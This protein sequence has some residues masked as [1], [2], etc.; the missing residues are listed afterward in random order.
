GAEQNSWRL[1]A[2]SRPAAV[3]TSPGHAPLPWPR[4]GGRT[5]SGQVEG[6]GR[7]GGGCA[8]LGRRGGRVGGW[9]GPGPPAFGGGSGRGIGAM[10]GRVDL[11]MAAG[12]VGSWPTIG[13]ITASCSPPQARSCWGGVPTRSSPRTGRR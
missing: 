8:G 12:Q 9:G 2:V 11:R 10:V 6:C 3:F 5:V 4:P 13:V 1:G 7:G